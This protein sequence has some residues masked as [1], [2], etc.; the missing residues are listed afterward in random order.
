M[1][2]NGPHIDRLITGTLRYPLLNSYYGSA[3]QKADVTVI[4]AEIKRRYLAKLSSHRVTGNLA[5]TARICGT[6]SPPERAS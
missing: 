3:E 1:A 5:R 2:Q 4:A 6:S